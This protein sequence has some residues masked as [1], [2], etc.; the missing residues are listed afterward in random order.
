MK[1]FKPKE[2]TRL[3][4]A[5]SIHRTKLDGPLQGAG[6][7]QLPFKPTPK[8]PLIVSASEIGSF[9][10]CRLQWN[11]KYRVGLEMKKY[12]PPRAIGII[13]HK[14]KEE[15]YLLPLRKRNIKRMKKIAA[16][17]SRMK[18]V[19]AI[20][21][22][23]ELARAM[24]TGYA[25]WALDDHETSDSAIGKGEV[26]PEDQFVLP[27]SKDRS[28]LVRGK[29]DERFEPTIYKKTLAMDETKTKN[30]IGFDMLDLNYQ[31]TTYLWAMSMKYPGYRRYQ[32]YRTVMRRQMPGPR[33]KAALFGRSDAIE[34]SPEE[35][36]IWLTDIQRVVADMLDAAIYPNMT[37]SCKWGCDFY[38]LCLVRAD[39]RDLKHVIKSEFTTKDV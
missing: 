10:R 24:L 20:P 9:L 36:D 29:I 38:N 5:K 37:D 12:G 34:R 19:D 16:E 13:V 8:Q 33:V 35:L 3:F 6:R 11:F 2:E 15:W 27:L 31:L 1:L 30:T 32:A 26:F 7:L 4:F 18:E 21:K 39:K 22:D 17:V 14:G 25:E 23:R 28:I